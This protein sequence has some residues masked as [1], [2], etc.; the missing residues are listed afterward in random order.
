MRTHSSVRDDEF[1][2]VDFDLE[3]LARHETGLFEP[4]AGYLEP[5]EE[6]RIG[7]VAAIG[8]PLAIAPRLLNGDMSLGVSGTCV[9]IGV[10]HDRLLSELMVVSG[11]YGLAPMRPALR[12][13]RRKGWPFSC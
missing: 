2:F 12:L 9:K 7:A 13:R 4:P 5:G 1:A 3:S 8:L 11:S 6:R 10:S